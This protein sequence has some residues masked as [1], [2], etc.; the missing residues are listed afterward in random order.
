[1]ELDGGSGQSHPRLL[2]LWG[3]RPGHP[4]GQ[5]T[6]WTPEPVWTWWEREKV[7]FGLPTGNQTLVVQP[8]A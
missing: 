1:L 2:Y 8:V 6:C 3:K 4:I 7:P 5:E